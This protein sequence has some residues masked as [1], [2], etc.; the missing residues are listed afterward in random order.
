MDL[1]YKKDTKREKMSKLTKLIKSP[2][3][4][5]QDAWRK[6][7]E[8]QNKKPL[9]SKL[10]KLDKNIFMQIVNFASSYPT[11]SMKVDEEYIWPYLRSHLWININYLS[12]GNTRY[13]TINPYGIQLGYRN[14]LP[15]FKR[16][17]LSIKYNIKEIAEIPHSINKLDFLFITS[18]NAAEHVFLDNGKIYNRISSPLSEV[19]NTIGSIERLEMVKVNTP[20]LKKVKDYDSVPTFVFAPNLQKSGYF[21]KLN[22]HRFFYRLFKLK[23]PSQVLNE[24]VMHNLVDWELHTRDYYLDLLTRMNPKVILLNGYHY[25]APLLSAA[26][27]LGIVTVDIQHGLQVGWN[28]LYNNWDEMPQEGYQA[29][30]DYFAVWGEK[31]YDNIQKVF[32]GKKHQPIILGNLWFEKQKSEV[33]DMSLTFKGTIK[34]Y[35]IKVLLVM[36]NQTEVPLFF[37]EIIDNAP[38]DIAWII[39]HHP[40]GTKFKSKDFS[41]INKTNIFLSKEIDDA[42]WSQLFQ[43]I[44][45]SISEG[46]AVA[47]EADGF[48]V[49]NII[50]SEEGKDNYQKEI[51]EEKFFYAENYETFFDILNSL[52]LTDKNPKVNAFEKVDV[53]SVL[54]VFLSKYEEKQQKIMKEIHA[55]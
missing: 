50:V 28:P 47:L 26:D 37:K 25:Y 24:S 5:F 41:K 53:L 43:Y 7:F 20:S 10:N 4:F 46:S 12:I 49:Y 15:F 11:S 21:E 13:K 44:D 45:V 36:Q 29:L 55:K 9:P 1:P 2:K 51:N 34:D 14:N 22:L 32:E 23:V 16:E 40:K 42:S 27:A 38:N 31:E 19:A 33:K 35:R 18:L 8:S 39:R 52:D 3:R 48:G 30:P 54:N 6:K 17:E